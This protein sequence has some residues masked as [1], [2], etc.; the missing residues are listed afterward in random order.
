MESPLR[1]PGNTVAASRALLL[2]NQI[3]VILHTDKLRP[4]VLFCSSSA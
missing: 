1:P 3:V 4:A 2:I